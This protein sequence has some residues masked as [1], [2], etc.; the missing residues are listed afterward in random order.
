M[1]NGPFIDDL[2]L[3][4]G[5]F[6]IV[7]LIYLSATIDVAEKTTIFLS[8]P[9]SGHGTLL[10][11]TPPQHVPMFTAKKTLEIGDF[12]SQKS[13]KSE[14]HLPNPDFQWENSFQHPNIVLGCFGCTNWKCPVGKSSRL[15][16]P[17]KI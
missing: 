8:D 5:D 7:M 3:K 11:G 9:S 15:D 14:N 10:S 16:V 12:S 13:K 2:A 4:H 6:S 17:N 1:E